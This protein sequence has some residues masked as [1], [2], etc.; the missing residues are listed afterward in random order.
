MELDLGAIFA[1]ILDKDG[2]EYRQRIG[3]EGGL[4][5]TKEAKTETIT[6]VSGYST[7]APET[8]DADAETKEIK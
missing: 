5:E 1:M 7:T 4:G 8:D 2:K 3:F 6:C